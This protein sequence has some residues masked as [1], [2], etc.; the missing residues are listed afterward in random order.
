MLFEKKKIQIETLSEY[1]VAVREDLQ[2]S[3]VEVSLKTSI[4]PVFLQALESGNFKLLPAEVY[5]FGFLRQLGRL[6]SVDSEELIGQFKKEKTIQRQLQKQEAMMRSS[7]PKKAFQKIVITP[8]ILSLSA[9]LLFVFLTVGYIIWQVWS[10]NR[11]PSLQIFEP[12]D[13]AVLQGSFVNVRGQTDPGINITINDQSIFVD[14]KGNFQTQLGLSSGPKEITV[15]AKNRFDKSVSR[16]INVTSGGQVHSDGQTLELRVDFTTHVTLGF[17]LDDQ[18][19]QTMDFNAGES[20]TFTA[21][22]KILLSTS[23]AGSTKVTLNGT[24]LGAMGRSKEQ[25][26]NIPFTAQN[27][28]LKK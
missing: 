20:K 2:L 3:A 17:S 12:Q 4:K 11:T 5:V 14:S 27:I 18:P 28:S 23:D 26:Q 25:L 22:Q 13:N 21:N 19:M 24:A 6:Y 8:K 10:I 7:W 1:L 9:G 15:T 16:T